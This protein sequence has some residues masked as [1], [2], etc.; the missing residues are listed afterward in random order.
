MLQKTKTEE[1]FIQEMSIAGY[2]DWTPTKDMI[3]HMSGIVI[4]KNWEKIGDLKLDIGE[5]QESTYEIRRYKEGNVHKIIVGEFINY[6]NKT[7]MRFNIAASIKLLRRKDIESW[8]KPKENIIGIFNVDGVVVKDSL[9]GNGIALS[10]Y[11]FLIKTNYIILGDETQYFGIRKTYA[12]LSKHPN[13]KMSIIDIE[14]EIILEK[15]VVVDQ[16]NEDYEFDDRV[17]SYT[18]EKKDVRLLLQTIE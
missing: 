12:R 4:S 11:K 13:L 9:R 14:K 7:A 3:H 15:D 16:G 6:D 1:E 17:W 8:I 2:G 18:T 10:F 5:E